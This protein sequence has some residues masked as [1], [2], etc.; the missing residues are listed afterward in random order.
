MVDL[1]SPS[2]ATAYPKI[3]FTTS[4]RESS[5]NRHIV[6]AICFAL[7]DRFTVVISSPESVIQQRSLSEYSLILY[8][9]SSLSEH[10]PLATMSAMARVSKVPSVFWAT[11]DPYEFDARY[12]AN[13]FDLYFSNDRNSATHFIERDHV[14]HLPL[15]ADPSDYREV[16]PL[17]E[18]KIGSFF[19]GYHYENRR[20]II[21]DV[22]A[23]PSFSR[24]D[25][26]V[27]GGDWNIPG[28]HTLKGTDQHSVVIDA[29]TKVRFV[30]NMGR[31]YDIANQYRKL[32]ATTPGPRTFECAIAGTPQIYFCNSLEIEEYYRPGSEIILVESADEAVERMRWLQDNATDYVALARAAQQRTASE[33]LYHHRIEKMLSVMAHAGISL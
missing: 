31:N 12:R 32:V 1:V 23:V 20:R 33:H 26:V 7:R 2:L 9:G 27:M 17:D 15:A 5:L 25:L 22:L 4:L 19:C 30:L 6:E 10:V 24:N 8:V 14:Y 21:S 11:D 13:D 16:N 29:Y 3:L 18:R 28:L